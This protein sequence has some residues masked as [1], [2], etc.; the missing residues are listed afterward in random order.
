MPLEIVRF[1]RAGKSLEELEQQHAATRQGP[2][3]SEHVRE[4][5]L[6]SL[7]KRIIQLQEE[8]VRYESAQHARSR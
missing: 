3:V 1:L 4:L 8:I 6:R 7:R 2:T 5:T